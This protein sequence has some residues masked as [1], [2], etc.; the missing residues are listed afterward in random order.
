MTVCLGCK[1]AFPDGWA[2]CPA[3][4]APAPARPPSETIG[5]NSTLDIN[6][7]Q[8]IVGSC[9]G[10]GGMGTVHSGWMYYN[11]SGSLAS[12]PPHQVAVKILHPYMASREFVRKLFVGEA[13]ALQKLNHPNIVHF[14]ALVETPKQLAIVIELVEGAALDTVIA[15]RAPDAKAARKPCLAFGRAWH[16]FEQLLGALA[17]THEL[18]IVHR[19]VKPANLLIRHDGLAKLTDFGIARLPADEAQR[20]GGLQPG[21][22]A[23]MSP[24]QVRGHHLDGRSDLYSAAI[25]LYEALAG[26]TPFDDGSGSELLVRK[27]QIEDPPPPVSSFLNEVP[28]VVDMLFARAL[29]KDPSN[30]FQTASELGNAFCDALG[31]PRT[32]GWKAQLEFARHATGIVPLMPPAPPAQDSGREIKNIER[33]KGN[34]MP[35]PQVEA[36]AM[37]CKLANVYITAPA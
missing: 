28:P 30:R 17:A 24:E 26:R 19:D 8:V 29:A 36:N 5:P 12:K 21:S 1:A 32:P 15:R 7:A 25:V 22:G 18:G 37:R 20:S 14:Y 13:T 10:T 33:K 3:C 27:S 4:G 2:S 9:I 31:L 11:P 6:W 34:T 23:Y 16:Y 35:I